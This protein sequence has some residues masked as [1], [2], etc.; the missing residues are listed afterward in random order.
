MN[1]VFELQMGAVERVWQPS[2]S[3]D[4]EQLSH[5]PF[6]GWACPVVWVSHGAI[7]AAGPLGEIEVGDCPQ[8]LIYRLL[9]DTLA[10]FLVGFLP[11]HDQFLQI[12]FLEVDLCQANHAKAASFPC[13]VRVD[14]GR[15]YTERF[16]ISARHLEEYLTHLNL[17]KTQTWPGPS[18][19]ET[20]R[21]AW[22][23]L[24]CAREAFKDLVSAKLP[25]LQSWCSPLSLPCQ[26]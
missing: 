25:S 13:V 5:E 24:S 3:R 22:E 4:Q 12:H 6:W 11:Q 23:L 18:P 17:P 10:G 15:L 16:W 20:Y 2:W 9:T 1:S 7:E 21:V 8:N 26:F 14:W 19:A